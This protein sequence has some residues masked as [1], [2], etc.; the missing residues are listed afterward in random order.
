MIMMKADVQVNRQDQ[1]V[2][3]TDL[4][5]TAPDSDSRKWW[6]S[7]RWMCEQSKGERRCLQKM[8]FS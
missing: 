1:L 2:L 5:L 6:V 3:K 7:M 8:N 4:L